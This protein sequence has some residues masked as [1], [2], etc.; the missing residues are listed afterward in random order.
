MLVLKSLTIPPQVT[1]ANDDLLRVGF[2]NVGINQTT[3]E[4]K[5]RGRAKAYLDRLIDDIKN[6]FRHHKLDVLGLCELGT[7][8]R[9]LHGDRNFNAPTQEDLMQH[10]VGAACR[11]YNQCEQSWCARA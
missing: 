10:V 7:H 11:R 1:E 6:G 4:Q 9:G 5:K 2:Y 3:L 8:L